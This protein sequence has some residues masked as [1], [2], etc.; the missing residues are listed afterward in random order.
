MTVNTIRYWSHESR[1]RGRSQNRE[2]WELE[3][4]GSVPGVKKLSFVLWYNLFIRWQKF[5]QVTQEQVD[6]PTVAD[7]LAY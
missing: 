4:F 7:F 3:K 5:L 6:I 2:D 1:Q